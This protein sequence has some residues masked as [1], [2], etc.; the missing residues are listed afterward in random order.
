MGKCSG[1]AG[2]VQRPLGPARRIRTVMMTSLTHPLVPRQPAP[3]RQ[4]RWQPAP[5]P[6]QERGDRQ[7]APGH[8]R[9]A[10]VPARGR[11]AEQHLGGAERRW[12]TW[13]DT[14]MPTAPT[15]AVT[16]API[17]MHMPAGAEVT[18]RFRASSI[19]R[20]ARLATPR[21][22][23]TAQVGAAV[24][25]AWIDYRPP[26]WKPPPSRRLRPGSPV[27]RSGIPVV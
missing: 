27:S 9:S 7:I 13:G 12:F 24:C 14:V 15:G 22:L 1:H 11:R 17:G 4:D 26:G 3:P 23:A 18:Y 8:D 10:A 21:T 25:G 2:C 16:I 20:L 19:A 6:G 5:R